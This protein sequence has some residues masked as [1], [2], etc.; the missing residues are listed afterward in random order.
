MDHIELSPAFES[1]LD[2]VS[3]FERD[4]ARVMEVLERF[5]ADYAVL[6]AAAVRSPGLADKLNTLDRQIRDLAERRYAA[7]HANDMSHA[8]GSDHVGPL[9]GWNLRGA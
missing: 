3:A 9:I 6:S 5:Q 4:E 1:D 2:E 8:K 7:Q